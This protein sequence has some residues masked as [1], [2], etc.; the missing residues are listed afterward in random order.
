MNRI[1]T[2]RHC[3]RL[4]RD[5]ADRGAASADS[6]NVGYAFQEQRQIVVESAGAE[7]RL[8]EPVPPNEIVDLEP[9][10]T[11]LQFVDDSLQ[12]MCK[13]IQATEEAN[14]GGSSRASDIA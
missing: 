1:E 3:L 9:L 14:A 4:F 7:D 13:R 10:L 12:N 6:A 11:E 8:F 5:I 2:A